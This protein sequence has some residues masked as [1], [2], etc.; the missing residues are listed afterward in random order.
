MKYASRSVACLMIGLLVAYVFLVPLVW[1]LMTYN[2]TGVTEH[3][4]MMKIESVVP[5]PSKEL[6]CYQGVWLKDGN[7]RGQC[8]VWEMTLKDQE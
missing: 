8:Y 7:F 4:N 1:T 6:W 2:Q 3:G 5:W